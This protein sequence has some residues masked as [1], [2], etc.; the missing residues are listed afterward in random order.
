MNCPKCNEIMKNMGEVQIRGRSGILSI[1]DH[2]VNMWGCPK[3]DYVEFYYAKKT[4]V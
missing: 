3:C 2:L 4:Y 1:S